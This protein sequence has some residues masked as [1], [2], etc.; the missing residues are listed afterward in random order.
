MRVLLLSDWMSNRGG[1]ES[2]ILSLREELLAQG[3]DVRLLTCGAVDSAEADI[4]ASGSDSIL[5]QT[6]LQVANPFAV[7]KV[8]DT[9]RDFEPQVAL[10]SHFAYHLSPAVLGALNSVPTV[11]SMMDY[12][13]VCPVGTKLLRDGSVCGVRA[14]F[15]CCTNRC[16]GI[17][18]WLRNVPRYAGIRNGL[19]TVD[20]ILCPSLSLQR[21]FLNAG[22]DAT[23]IPLGV[24]AHPRAQGVPSSDPVFCYIGR[25]AR[26]KGV[27]LLLAALARCRSDF[28]S[29][30]VRI[31]GDGPLRRDLEQLA[32]ML[33]VAEG[34]EFTGWVEESAVDDYRA[35]AWACVCPSLWA[36]PF[37][38]AAIGATLAGVPVIASD[39]GG[40]VETVEPGVSG[41]LFRTANVTAL[42]EAM[43]SI[44]SGE[45]FPSHRLD[46]TVVTRA[47]QQHGVRQHTARLRSLFSEMIA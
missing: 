14:G 27:A 31:V 36:E 44:A 24:T 20:R 46:E 11:V 47:A 30:R 5:A 26:E 40:F 16:I 7:A 3:D 6:F 32:S 29:A 43:I 22:I 21:E 23:V 10:V 37:G 39:S 18:H 17:A 13:A 9:I 41:L 34:V 35:D 38:I 12:K 19:S 2:Y 42:T 33:G 8:R 45:V 25:L 1:A 28:P 15:V 4:T